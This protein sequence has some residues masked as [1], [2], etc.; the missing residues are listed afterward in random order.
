MAKLN[1]KLQNQTEKAESSSF[2]PLDPGVYHARLK[3]VDTTKSGAKGPYWSWEF[4]VVEEPYVNRK[5]WTNTSL[6]EAAA[7]KMKEMFEAFDVPLDTDTDD[8]LG[9]IVRVQVSIRTIQSGSKKG[10]LSNQ[11]DKVLP[12]DEDFELPEGVASGDEAPVSIFDE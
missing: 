11:V 3:D 6:S 4:Q 2:D 5:L 1:K 8:M 7:F 10:E 9:D 12:K